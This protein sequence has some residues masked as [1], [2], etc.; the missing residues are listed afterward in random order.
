[1]LALPL[2]ANAT[3]YTSA[4]YVQDGLVLQL[5]GIDNA[6]RGIHDG[7]ATEWKD[8]SPSGLTIRN[9][10]T[11]AEWIWDE[12]SV[13]VGGTKPINLTVKT[14]PLNYRHV[15]FEC[16]SVRDADVPDGNGSYFW[17]SGSGWRFNWYWSKGKTDNSTIWTPGVNYAASLA[18]V[19]GSHVARMDGT[20]I[21]L[22]SSDSVKQSANT[23]LNGSPDED[24]VGDLHIGKNYSIEV[25]KSKISA[26]RVYNRALTDTEIRWNAAVDRARFAGMAVA[27]GEVKVA[28]TPDEVASPQPGY[29]AVTVGVS[30]NNT[31]TLG[32]LVTDD[33]DG[34]RVAAEYVDSG[35]RYVYTGCNWTIGVVNPTVGSSEEETVS[36]EKVSLFNDLTWNFRKDYRTIASSLE[37]GTVTVG[38]VSGAC[39]TNFSSE[40][41]LTIRA[42]ADEAAGYSFFQ[43]TGDVTDIDDPKQAEIVVP[44]KSRN[45]VATYTWEDPTHVPVTT[46]WKPANAS[47]AWNDAANWDNGV[48][49]KGD[50][51]VISNVTAN[52]TLTVPV[53]TSDL[54]LLAVGNT[55]GKTTKIVQDGWNVSIKAAT[56]DLG[57]GV[58]VTC[59]D[60][61]TYGGDLQRVHLKGDRLFLRAG[62]KINVNEKGYKA[63][64]GPCWPNGSTTSNTG[65]GYAGLVDGAGQ[66]AYGSAENPTDPGSG[67]NAGPGGGAVRL[68]FS[69]AVVIDGDVTAN[70]KYVY[71]AS[72]SGSGGSVWISAKTIAGSGRVLANA[73]NP[74]EDNFADT[75]LTGGG[76]RVAVHYDT[77]AQTA[78]PCNIRFEARGGMS[79]RSSFRAS[80]DSNSGNTT[81]WRLEPNGGP[82][83]IW[84][85]DNSFLTSETY[86]ANGWKFAGVWMSPEPLTA[87]TIPDNLLLDA[88]FVNFPAGGFVLNVSGNLK[89][90]GV[91]FYSQR[92]N[93]L[94]L[95]NGTVTIAGDLELCAARLG[96]WGGSVSVGG[97]ATLKSC[98]YKDQAGTTRNLANYELGGGEI[99]IT[100]APTAEAGEVGATVTVGG[101]LSLAKNSIIRPTC[102][103]DTGSIVSF[104]V[105]NLVMDAGSYVSATLQGFGDRRGPGAASTSNSAASYGGKGGAKSGSEGLVADT[106]GD[107]KRPLLPGSGTG[108]NTATIRGFKGGGVVYMTATKSMTLNGTIEADGNRNRILR[109][110]NG[111]PGSS[112]GS[113]YLSTRRLCASTG[114]IYARGGVASANNT[115]NGDNLCTGGGGRIAVWMAKHLFET[116]EAFEAFKSNVSAAAGVTVA[117]DNYSITA[118]NDETHSEDGTVYWGE[119][120]GPGLMLLVR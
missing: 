71:Q 81:A 108:N 23:G 12:N 43:W 46:A 22:W 104:A 100:A 21:T 80:T 120:P 61:C 32:G 78:V 58:E 8:L 119:N 74:W 35:V 91:G 39:V 96:N 118:W 72:G 11:G 40:G 65:G 6:G 86:L 110:D 115:K 57:K 84:F 105:K 89:A 31:F 66:T 109:S 45:I 79:T 28:A 47:G 9:S 24:Y 38:G 64:T 73:R 67:S 59:A 60:A 112:G 54:A 83:T 7:T 48:P 107:E 103:M 29:G 50:T 55:N 51:V 37:G 94:V 88:S 75:R 77:A 62:A 19:D 56:I 82:G 99:A 14:L 116:E 101:T 90:T 85:S 1:M 98:S 63:K 13:Y 3:G 27:E 15:T 102:D 26:F 5:D 17:G 53:P 114:F 113:V 52:T 10:N 34:A 36:F 87:L 93:G 92:E 18:Y 111:C 30:T 25:V 70:G 16:Y 4:D 20:T 49:Q 41:T 2:A 44:V 33:Y 42:T 117:H 97:N 95:S 69:D 68:E 106:Y 76:G